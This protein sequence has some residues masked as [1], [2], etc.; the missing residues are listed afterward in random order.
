MDENTG[1][2]KLDKFPQDDKEMGSARICLRSGGVKT[3]NKDVRNIPRVWG[4]EMLPM[5]SH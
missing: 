3:Q 2:S 5:T 4:Q 1:M